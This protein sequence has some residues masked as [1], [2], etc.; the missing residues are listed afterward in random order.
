MT[1]QELT[2]STVDASIASLASKMTYT[3]AG[4]IGFGWLLSSEAAVFFG[5]IGVLMGNL[6][7][8]WF[9]RKADKREEEI[10]RL[11]VHEYT[12]RFLDES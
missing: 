7:N 3:S 1:R 8:W 9:K 2:E 12:T 10:H 4:S 5:I 11:K 6:V